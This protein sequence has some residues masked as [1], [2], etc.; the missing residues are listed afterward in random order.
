M[1]YFYQCRAELGSGMETAQQEA[2]QHADELDPD[3]QADPPTVQEI[4]T[5]HK[6]CVGLG[7]HLPNVVATLVLALAQILPAGS[8]AKAPYSTWCHEKWSRSYATT[9]ALQEQIFQ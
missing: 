9:E 4:E 5:A 1:G 2:A 6:Y 3:F 7:C 8:V